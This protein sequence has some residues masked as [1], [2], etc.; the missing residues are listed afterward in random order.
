MEDRNSNVNYLFLNKHN[1]VCHRTKAERA[2]KGAVYQL[3]KN[4][5]SLPSVFLKQVKQDACTSETCI[6]YFIK[7]I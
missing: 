3:N 7:K 1:T 4:L 6:V 5:F 2:T